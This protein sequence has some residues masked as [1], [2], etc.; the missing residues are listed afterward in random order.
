[1]KRTTT[2]HSTSFVYR[3]NITLK[4]IFNSISIALITDYSDIY[5]TLN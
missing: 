1:M 4:F 5:C 2:K 3:C